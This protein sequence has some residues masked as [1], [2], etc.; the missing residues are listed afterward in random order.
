MTEQYGTFTTGDAPPSTAY[1]ADD[2]S[3]AAQKISADAY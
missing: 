1:I 2:V 3:N